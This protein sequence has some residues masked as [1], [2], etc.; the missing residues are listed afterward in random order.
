[1]LSDFV[2]LILREIIK[3]DV[4]MRTRNIAASLETRPLQKFFKPFR[5]FGVLSDGGNSREVCE[6][7]LE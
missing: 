5:N 3:G 4:E 7:M 2:E 1:M 6:Y